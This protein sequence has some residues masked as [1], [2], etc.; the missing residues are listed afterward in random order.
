M[1]AEKTIASV[2][3]TCPPLLAGA[4]DA[5][6]AENLARALKVIADPARLRILSLI[7]AQPEAEA[8]VCHLTEPLGLSQPTVSHHLKVLLEAGL[9]EREQR[10]SWAYFRIVDHQLAALRELLA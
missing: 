7:Q 5:A 10:G 1:G 9:V 8:C 2:G 4:L 3:A 6:H